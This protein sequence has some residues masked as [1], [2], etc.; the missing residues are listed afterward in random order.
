MLSPELP[1]PRSPRRPRC[2]APISTTSASR[3]AR[4]AARCASGR[5][6]ADAIELVVFDDTDLDWITDTLRLVP[7]R[8]RRVDGHDAR[9]CTP[10][11][12]TP[13]ASTARRRPATRST[14]ARSS[15]SRTRAD[16]S[17]AGYDDWRS[18]AVDGSFDWGGVAQARRP[19]R[20]HG[21]L[22][23]PRQGPVEAAPG[24]PAGAA[25]H[26]RRPRPPG[27]DRALPDDSASRA[28]ELL[29]VHAFATEPRLL[30]HGPRELLGLQ[31]ARLLHPARRLRDRREPRG[32]GPR[33]CCASSRAW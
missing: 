1:S 16:S 6:R 24:V 13:S 3:S 14:A 19:A 9:C 29:P 5:A 18:V 27:D 15:S 12:A 23:G 10:V 30:Q 8:R 32:R 25:R 26:L 31:H 17:A 28:I 20:P 33:R 11:R 21:H 4:T 2:S 7:G 22:R